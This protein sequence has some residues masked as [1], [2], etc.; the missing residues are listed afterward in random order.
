MAT[1][2]SHADVPHS[3]GKPLAF[4]NLVFSGERE[5]G[6]ELGLLSHAFLEGCLFT[7]I[8]S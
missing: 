2:E 6:R 4:S 1:T 5:E 3:L 7:L 8:V